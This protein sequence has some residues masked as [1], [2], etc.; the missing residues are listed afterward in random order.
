MKG[1][2]IA[3]NKIVRFDY[4]I[5]FPADLRTKGSESGWDLATVDMN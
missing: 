3:D 4:K 2:L 1:V 5:S